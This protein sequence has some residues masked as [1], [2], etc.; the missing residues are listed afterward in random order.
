M[1][2]SKTTYGNN[3]ST[4]VVQY[5]LH[6]IS[7]VYQCMYTF[8]I[9]I[10]SYPRIDILNAK[11]TKVNRWMP[12][13]FEKYNDISFNIACLPHCLVMFING[14]RWQYANFPMFLLLQPTKNQSSITN[15]CR[16]IVLVFINRGPPT[17]DG[18]HRWRMVGQDPHSSRFAQGN[19]RVCSLQVYGCGSIP[20]QSW[21]TPEYHMIVMSP[22]L[23]CFELLITHQSQ[24]STLLGH[25]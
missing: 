15:P 24:A 23:R 1:A 13:M 16:F 4:F 19:L 21:W 10:S 14:L 12:L 6:A 3:L 25:F 5:T 17:V 7:L 8:Y 18:L 11:N 2:G 22:A 20:L 9:H